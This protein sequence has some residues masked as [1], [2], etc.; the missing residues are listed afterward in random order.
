MF[1]HFSAL[2]LPD[3]LMVVWTLPS[4][5]PKE[6]ISPYFLACL[7]GRTLQELCRCTDE[8]PAGSVR[9]A[10]EMEYHISITASTNS[11]NDMHISGY[12]ES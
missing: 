9:L 6:E 4:S 10:P 3:F 8:A 1:H 2:R 5:L 7:Q 12:P 11:P